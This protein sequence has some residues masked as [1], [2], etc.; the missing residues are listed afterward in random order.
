MLGNS[1]CP[2]P[3]PVAQTPPEAAY[4]PDMPTPTPPDRLYYTGDEAA[5]RLIAHDPLAL[6]IGL[7]LDQQVTVQ[8][9]F[10]GPLELQRRLGALD[11]GEIAALDPERLA[12]AF[13]E[14]PAIHRFPGAMARR[15]QELCAAIARD[16]GSDASRIWTE[17]KDA[18]D[19]E[20]RLLALPGF[21]ELKAR[22]MLGIL[23]K[24]FAVRL[25]GWD[26]V[27]PRHA[28][29]GDVDSEA[30]LA[31]YQAGKRAYKATLRAGGPAGSGGTAG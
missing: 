22:T 19:L 15:V 25:A 1:C 23:G 12:Q 10:S 4:H 29:L 20:T 7:Q 13:R 17:A 6:L 9:A 21:G 24:R 3:T 18:R 14:R 28:T 30:S 27:A 26:E 16:Y 8:K 5:D 11:A 31:T 2:N